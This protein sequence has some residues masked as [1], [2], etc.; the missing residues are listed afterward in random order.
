[1]SRLGACGD[2]RVPADTPSV[3]LLS[4]ELDPLPTDYRLGYPPPRH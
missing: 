3:L 1:M 2:S 4:D